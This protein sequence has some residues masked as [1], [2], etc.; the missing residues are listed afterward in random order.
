MIIYIVHNFCKLILFEKKNDIC[1]YDNKI[2][3]LKSNDS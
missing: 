3:L 1:K 2:I